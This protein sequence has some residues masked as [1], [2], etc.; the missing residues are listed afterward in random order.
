MDDNEDMNGN[1][2]RSVE[3]GC[4]GKRS[5]RQARRRETESK[6]K[7]IGKKRPSQNR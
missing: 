4:R 1:T 7:S 2:K 6:G 5:R 3:A